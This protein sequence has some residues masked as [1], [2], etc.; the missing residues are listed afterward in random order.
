MSY[1]AYAWKHESKI[2][3][4]IKNLESN[5]FGKIPTLIISMN[6]I[7][8]KISVKFLLSSRKSYFWEGFITTI[9][10]STLLDKFKYKN[11][12][13]IIIHFQS[14]FVLIKGN[15]SFFLNHTYSILYHI[16]VLIEIR[17]FKIIRLIIQ[18]IN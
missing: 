18:K 3:G 6:A 1:K 14:P 2:T 5:V 8:W 17:I 4:Q 13:K 10:S 9:N 11:L 7:C 16:I 12:I 15:R